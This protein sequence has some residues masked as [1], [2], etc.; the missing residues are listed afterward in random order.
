MEKFKI[1][2]EVVINKDRAGMNKGEKGTV[3]DTVSGLYTLEMSDGSGFYNMLPED[4]DAVISQEEAREL[5]AAVVAAYKQSD[6]F[7][8]YSE[9]IK[10]NNRFDNR[11]EWT[12]RAVG[13]ATA[14]GELRFALDKAL[15]KR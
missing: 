5:K 8:Q 11:P 13:Y 9:N 6:L 4:L 3:V 10:Y 15:G 7:Q 2:D 14:S 12:G 1:G